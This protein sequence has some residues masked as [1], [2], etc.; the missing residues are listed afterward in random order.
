MPNRSHLHNVGGDY[1]C[2][3]PEET[4]ECTL[5]KREGSLRRIVQCPQGSRTLEAIR[6]PLSD[7]AVTQN[8]NPVLATGLDKIV[9]KDADFRT[10]VEAWPDLAE[11]TKTT[12]RTLIHNQE[13]EHRL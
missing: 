10:L 11:D 4:A 9:Q 3:V 1:A 2:F 8:Q 6:Q 7:A 5:S 13:Q 12:I